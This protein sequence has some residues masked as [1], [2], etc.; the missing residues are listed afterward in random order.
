[1]FCFILL[2][3]GELVCEGKRREV[4]E[5]E[6]ERRGERGNGDVKRGKSKEEGTGSVAELGTL[7]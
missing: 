6:E 1:L 2:F 3:G 4:G 5:E 7:P